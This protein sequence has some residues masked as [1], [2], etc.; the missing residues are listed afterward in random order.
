MSSPGSRSISSYF[1]LCELVRRGVDG[2]FEQRGARK[3]NA[4]GSDTVTSYSGAARLA[5]FERSNHHCASGKPLAAGAFLV[6]N[7]RALT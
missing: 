3:R 4:M 2:V 7:D 1:L 5:S 6:S